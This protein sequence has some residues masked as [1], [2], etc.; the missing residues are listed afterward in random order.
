ME[1]H[2]IAIFGARALNSITF[3]TV[4]SAGFLKVRFLRQEASPKR[5][6]YVF[7]R[8]ENVVLLA[9]RKKAL[10]MTNDF[11]SVILRS[12]FEQNLG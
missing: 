8:A 4:G 1:N 12:F 2:R 11:R 10:T 9:S 6:N 7:L 3:P 5:L